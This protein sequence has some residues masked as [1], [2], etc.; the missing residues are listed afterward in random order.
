MNFRHLLALPILA[1]AC[2]TATALA[3][4]VHCPPHLGRVVVDGNVLVAAPCRLEGTTVKGN[5]HLY[6]GGSLIAVDA[7][8]DGNIQAERAD[9]VDVSS[10]AVGG[11]VQLDEM[12]GDVSRVERTTVGGSIQLE[13]NRSRLEVLDSEIGADVQAF[14]NTGGV[15]IAGNTIDGNL[16]CKSNQP[17]PV[18]GSNRVHGNKEDQCAN[19]QA[20]A[21][22][23]ANAPL[24]SMA[25]VAT[26]AGAPSSSAEG[27]GGGA[28]GAF[29]A[30][31]VPALA[32]QLFARRRRN[33]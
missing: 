1:Q 4:D 5:V 28:M 3:G 18:G 14:S 29:A 11:S 27:G 25:A 17:Q 6:S 31:L 10:T 15:L 2:W 26:N 19:L 9:F 30:L 32:W 13:G 24:S 33:R 22:A 7:N 21:P 20:E 8:I 12:V 16:Q 23:G